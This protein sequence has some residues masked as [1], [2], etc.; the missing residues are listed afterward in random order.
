MVATELAARDLSSLLGKEA[1]DLL[2]YK[3]KVPKDTLHLPGK[4]FVERIFV[5]SDR[6]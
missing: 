5:Y 4:D 3:A 6:K 2:T 1:E